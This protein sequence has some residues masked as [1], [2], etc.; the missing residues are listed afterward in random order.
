[1]KLTPAQEVQIGRDHY[2]HGVAYL[3]VNTAGHVTV[4]DPKSVTI[5]LDKDGNPRGP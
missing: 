5:K 2:T 4:L 1:M 3:K